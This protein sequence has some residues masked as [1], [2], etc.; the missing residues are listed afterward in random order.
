[1]SAGGGPATSGRPDFEQ[2]PLHRHVGLE[3]LDPDQPHLGCRFT[4]APHLDG[5]EG[6]LNGG[7]LSMILDATAFLALEPLLDDDEDAISHDLHISMLR[8]VRTG[9][10][11]ELRGTVVQ[12]GRRVAFVNS[13]ATV[14]GRIVASARITKSIV[15]RG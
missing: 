8:G 9:D 12:R 3:F 13:E 7:V 5:R 11:V 14:N 6:S 1:M 2:S 15:Q 10:V 4:A